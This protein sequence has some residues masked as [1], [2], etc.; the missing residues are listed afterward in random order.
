MDNIFL[1]GPEV[2][3]MVFE[4]REIRKSG[5]PFSDI[6]DGGG[7]YYVDFVQQGG[8]VL[9]LALG[10]YTYILEQAGIR[11]YHLGGTSAGAI[12]VLLMASLAGIGESVSVKILDIFAKKNIFDFV[13][14]PP[15]IKKMIQS[16]VEGKRG[17]A[18]WHLMW[19]FFR[20]YRLMKNN[21]GLNPGDNIETWLGELLKT[22]NIVTYR[23]LA[24]LRSKPVGVRNRLGIDK[25]IPKPK[26][27]I[28]TSDITT[29][30]RVELPRMA[31][32]YWEDV[33][34][35]SPVKFVRASM[36]VPY[37]YYP[38][39]KRNLPNA[40]EPAT[41]KWNKFADYYGRIPRK[42]RFVDGGLLSNFPINVFHIDAVPAKPT[43]G[44]RLS[45]FRHGHASTG[46]FLGFSGALIETMR[47]IHD[48]EINLQNPDYRH[49]IC[50]IAADEEFNWLDF[51]MSKERQKQLFLLGAQ[52]AL[53]FLHTFDWEN[54]KNIRRSLLHT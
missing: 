52:K 37:F 21:L 9:G 24:E 54:Y 22:N 17:M 41:E 14:G 48:Y 51:N 11:F 47:Q 40:G 43:F 34:K 29:H 3:R 38:F 12:N 23:D 7:N 33:N 26:I 2:T 28:I 25:P 6:V 15:G 35:I 53:D 49:L 20:I 19:N 4:A 50:N 30:T 32:L 5:K 18:W 44:A 31:D 39:I 36:A 27:A 46:T 8:G 45:S 1:T 16:E 13:D 10:G 42:V